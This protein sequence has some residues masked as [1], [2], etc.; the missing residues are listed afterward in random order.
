MESKTIKQDPVYHEEVVGIAPIDI[1]YKH[2][3]SYFMGKDNYQGKN[4]GFSERILNTLCIDMDEIETD[5]GGS[6]KN[7]MDLTI[8]I[9]EYDETLQSFS[10]NRILP[11]ELKLGCDTFNRIKKKDLLDKDKHT[12]DLLN[13]LSILTDKHSIFIFTKEVTPSAIYN[14]SRWDKESNSNDIK[15]WKMMSPSDYNEYIK[16]KEDYPYKAI[17]DLIAISKTISDLFAQQDFDRCID[18]IDKQK[19]EAEKYKIKYNLNECQKIAETLISSINNNL[20]NIIPPPYN[21][22]FVML[23]DEVI[24]LIK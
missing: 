9:A 10:F 24:S 6:N 19:K 12:R 5:R 17:S 18:Y 8:G 23:R 21:E 16:F 20:T 13:S 22:F 3:F 7:T 2:R 4:F 14:K 1:K 15:N 11:V